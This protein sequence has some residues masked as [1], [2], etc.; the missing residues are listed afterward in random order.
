MAAHGNVHLEKIFAKI[1]A[2]QRE[3]IARLKSWVEIPSISCEPTRRG[4]IVRMAKVAKAVGRLINRRNDVFQ[5]LEHLGATAE[6]VP[7]G[8]QKM[9]DGCE[10]DLPPLVMATLVCD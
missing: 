6:L 4:E 8:K 3:Y 1:D 7:L 9:H 5:M 2:D 10:I